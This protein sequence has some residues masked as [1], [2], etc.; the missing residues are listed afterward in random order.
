MTKT[1]SLGAGCLFLVVGL[2]GLPT[3]MAAGMESVR[4]RLEAATSP[5]DSQ[6]VETAH[7][8]PEKTV[9]S[10]EAGPGGTFKV[11]ARKG[12]IARFRCS[13]C[14]TEKKV[15]PQIQ[16]GVS[17]THGDIT[18]SHGKGV[19]QLACLECHDVSNRDFLV[20]KKGEL[21]DFDHSYQLCG[22]CHFRQ[23]RDWLGGAHGKRIV[24]WAGER[25][26][27][28]CTG[29]HNAHAPAFPSKMPAT[30]SLPLDR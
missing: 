28:N 10:K 24:Y 15:T 26:V 5:F 2:A 22:Q 3:A 23:Q 19:N 25:V 1:R 17:S 27:Q 21:I 12:E 9:L 14:H 13:A 11:A 20:D 4:E 29:C 8:I 6:Q 18:V 16:D 7:E 30:Y